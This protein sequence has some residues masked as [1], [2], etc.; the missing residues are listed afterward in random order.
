V[1]DP[2]PERLHKWRKQAKYHA[3]QMR[4]GRRVYPGL[5]KRIR[6]T[7]D[8]AEKLGHLQDIE[9]L[10]QAIAPGWDDRRLLA[11]ELRRRDLRIEARIRGEK[12]F[13]L[14]RGA[15]AKRLLA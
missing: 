2:T 11:L 8:L 12:L 3:L 9:V 7:R 13:K 15:W 1:T 14:R 6:R 10:R 4:I 5:A